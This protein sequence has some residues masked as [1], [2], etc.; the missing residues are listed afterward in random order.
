MLNH[1]VFMG[2]ITRDP[3]LRKTAT[4]K[5]VVSFSIACDRPYVADREKET[6]FIDCTAW[7]GTAEFIARNFSKGSLIIVAGRM[8]NRVW[9]DK[10]GNNRKTTEL[11]VSEAEFSGEKPDKS[12]KPA[13]E[14]SRY[15]EQ[16]TKFEEVDEDE[17]DDLPF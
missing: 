1:C 12:K 15:A 3:E 2:R 10:E 6:D 14:K 16:D 4:D 8:Q 7:R 17:T 13:P 5:S 9:T 11:V